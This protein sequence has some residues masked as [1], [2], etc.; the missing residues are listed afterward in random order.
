MIKKAMAI[1]FVMALLVSFQP[2]G[3]AMMKD[4]PRQDSRELMFQD[5]LMLFLLPHIDNE[6]ADI[7]KDLLTHAPVVYPYFADVVH[8]ERVNGFRGF[9]FLVTLEIVPTV[10]PHIPVGK[11]RMTFDISPVNPGN[12]KLVFRQHLKD[13]RE[14]DFPPN[15]ADLLKKSV[16]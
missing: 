14:S 16:K 8:V 11:D 3:I 1:L 2:A 4:K 15:Y 13:P 5:M 6:V 12:V 7:Y 9:H 10:G